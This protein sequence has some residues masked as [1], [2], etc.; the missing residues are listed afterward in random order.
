M[1]ACDDR[2]RDRRAHAPLPW[3][4]ADIRAYECV[5]AVTADERYLC[6]AWMQDAEKTPPRPVEGDWRGVGGGE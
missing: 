4:P 6:T 2:N 1:R 3:T 5:L